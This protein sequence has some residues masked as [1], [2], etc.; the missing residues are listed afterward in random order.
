M[1][2]NVL[3]RKNE[4]PSEKDWN[5]LKRVIKY[6]NSTKGLN[7]VICTEAPPILETCIDADWAGDTKRRRS[8]TGNLFLLG[9]N[10]IQRVTKRQSCIAQSSAEAEYERRQLQPKKLYG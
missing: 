1:A 5:V 2:I 9:K 8:T 4:S 6:L 7:L 3:S 10:P